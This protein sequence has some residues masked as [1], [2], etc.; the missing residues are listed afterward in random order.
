[1]IVVRADSPQAARELLAQDPFHRHGLR[2][3]RVMPWQLNEGH[4][5]LAA[6][7]SSGE[8]VLR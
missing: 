8:L 3:F 7:L 5:E 4:I 1:V 2:T 6:T